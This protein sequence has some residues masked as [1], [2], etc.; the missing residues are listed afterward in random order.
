[1]GLARVAN[2]LVR[3]YY[4]GMIRRLEIAQSTLHRP[5]LVF[6]AEPTVGLDPIARSAVWEHLDRL[7]DNYGTT[8]FFTT[9]YM[10]EAENHCERVAIMHMGSL[11]ALG[12]RPELK[13]SIGGQNRTFDEVFAH[14]AGSTL[15][16]GGNYRDVSSERAT[17]RR[18]G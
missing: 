3:K 8:T 6:L 2:R 12:I 11:A 15:D 1:M 13:A 18:L 16:S 7:R 9:H 4:G 17:E 5:R 14:F 10:D